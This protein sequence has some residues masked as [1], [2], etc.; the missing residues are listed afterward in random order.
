M[1]TLL[2]LYIYMVITLTDPLPKNPINCSFGFSVAFNI[3]KKQAYNM[4]WCHVFIKKLIN[5]L[6]ANKFL[7]YIN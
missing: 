7:L 2:I 4:I 5:Y 1:K 6:A 3:K